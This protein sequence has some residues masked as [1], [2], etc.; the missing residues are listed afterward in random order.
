[1]EQSVLVPLV[2]AAAMVAANSKFLD[3]KSLLPTEGFAVLSDHDQEVEKYNFG[4]AIGAEI[5]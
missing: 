1:M 5:S 3:Y 2:L 4:G